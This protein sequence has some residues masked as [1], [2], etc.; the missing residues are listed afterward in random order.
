MPPAEG[1]ALTYT[2]GTYVSLVFTP[3]LFSP[4]HNPLHHKGRPRS[5]YPVV[6]RSIGRN[7]LTEPLLEHEF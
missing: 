1:S 4:L 7:T 5:F 6:G 2:A 3:L